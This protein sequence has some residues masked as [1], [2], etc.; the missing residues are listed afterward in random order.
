MAIKATIFKAELAVSDMDRGVYG[1]FSLTI[2]RHPS[3]TDERMMVRLLAF[4]LNS[5]ERLEFGKGISNEDEPALWRRDLTGAIEQWIDVGLPEERLLRR[6]CGKAQQVILLT[7]GGR[8]VDVW[9]QQNKKELVKQMRLA[10]M[11][12]PQEASRALA[13]L[14]DRNMVLTATIQEGQIYFSDA[15]TSVAM[16]LRVLHPL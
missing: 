5:D 2:A 6:A 15:D 10:V 7:Y 12:V 9:W 4:A 3:E 16:E 1:D 14:V 13:A 8:G 11:D